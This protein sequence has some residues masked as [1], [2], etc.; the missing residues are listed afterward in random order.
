MPL[1]ASRSQNVIVNDQAQALA[2]YVGVLGFRKHHDVPAGNYKWLTV[3]SPAPGIGGPVTLGVRKT[4]ACDGCGEV[5]L[6]ARCPCHGTA[7]CYECCRSVEH[8]GDCPAHDAA[9]EGQ[10]QN[11]GGYPLA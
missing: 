6:T 10:Q 5:R 4:A 7:L 11:R 8:L 9:L 2:F 1:C 3:V